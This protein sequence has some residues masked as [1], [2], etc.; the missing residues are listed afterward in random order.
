MIL[1]DGC[2]FLGKVSLEL[3]VAWYGDHDV[4][5]AGRLGKDGTIFFD[6]IKE[7]C[8]HV[9]LGLMVERKVLGDETIQFAA[10]RHLFLRMEEIQIHFSISRYRTAMESGMEK[11]SRICQ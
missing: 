6:K 3:G 9:R 1:V 10:R 2:F 11:E 8:R 5:V 7:K 4:L